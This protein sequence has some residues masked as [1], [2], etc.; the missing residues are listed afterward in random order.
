MAFVLFPLPLAWARVLVPALLLVL[1]PVLLKENDPQ[2]R[3][4]TMPGEHESALQQTTAFL[5]SFGSN[6]LRLF[7]L[8]LPWMILAAVLGAV[9]AEA[10]PAYGTHL[11]VSALGV[12][13]VAVLGT[14]LPVPM[15]LDVALA[16]VLYRSGVPMPYVAALLCT[17]GPLSIYSLSALALQLGRSTALRL[18][19]T[20]AALGWLAG[21]LAMILPVG[22]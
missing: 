10:I 4:I 3:A 17:L 15:A 18:A 11:P 2:V 12:I 5:R 1:L 7:L 13:A 16:F 19:A 9:L 21:W 6:L 8:T 14:L 20:L 22:S